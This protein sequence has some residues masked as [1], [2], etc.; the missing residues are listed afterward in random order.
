MKVFFRAS[1]RGKKLFGENYI[2]I[3][4]A[5]K[6][7]GYVTLD[8]EV[9]NQ[10]YEDY[11]KLVK[12]EGASYYTKQFNDSIAKMKKADICV[13][14]G[15]EQSF[16]VGYMVHKALELNKPTVVLY[17]EERPVHFL[18]DLHEEKLFVKSYTL[19]NVKDVLVKTLKVA[20]VAIDKRFN[21]FI[22][23]TLLN[24]LNEVAKEEGVTKSTFIRNL[25][26]DHR[27]KSLAD[28]DF[29]G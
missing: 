26:S 29:F 3:N 27:R 14:E 9:I 1:Q 21:F 25:I 22:S 23:P 6:E 16:S 17:V 5:I 8:D 10:N 7:L 4:N 28:P 15:S 11:S 19:D 12:K 24:F 18:M 2:T 13:F 20:R